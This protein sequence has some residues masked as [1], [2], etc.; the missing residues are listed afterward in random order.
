MEQFNLMSSS[1]KKNEFAKWKVCSDYN[2]VKIIGQGS[3]GSVAESIHIPSGRKV[4]IRRM[5][6]LFGDEEDCKK[7][8]REMQ[9]LRNMRTQYSTKLLDVLEPEN[10]DTYDVLYI[11]EDYVDADIKKVL[12]SSICLTEVHI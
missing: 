6:D 12:R 7:M 9:L 3:Y 4:A 5:D 10:M 8:I 1:K 11:V 2:L